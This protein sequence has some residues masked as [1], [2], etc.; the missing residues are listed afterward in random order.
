MDNWDPVKAAA[1]GGKFSRIS[2]FPLTY[3]TFSIDT[4]EAGPGTKIGSA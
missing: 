2:T 3:L 4:P 1:I